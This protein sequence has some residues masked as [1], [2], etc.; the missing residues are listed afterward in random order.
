MLNNLLTVL[1]SQDDAKP[2]SFEHSEIQHF[3]T[4]PKLV[5]VLSDC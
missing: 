4:K 1:V 5:F 2:V 3:E